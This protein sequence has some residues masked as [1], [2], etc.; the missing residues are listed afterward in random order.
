LWSLP[1]LQARARIRRASLLQMSLH[2]SSMEPGDEWLHLES[3]STSTW[4][5]ERSAKDWWIKRPAVPTAN[6]KSIASLTMLMHWTIWNERNARVF[7]HKSTPPPIFLSIIKGEARLWLAA[8]AK[9]NDPLFRVLVHISHLV[10]LVI[11]DN[12]ICGLTV[13]IEH[14]RY[15]I[16]WHK[17]V[18]SPQ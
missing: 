11:D 15:S 13:C 16:T 17:T 4:H 12:A 18:Y 1:S 9:K 8:G 6:R 14:F 7:R 3:I 10:V 5:L 2:N